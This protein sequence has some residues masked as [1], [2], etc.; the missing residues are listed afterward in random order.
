MVP[1][2][3]KSSYILSTDAFHLTRWNGAVRLTTAPPLTYGSQQYLSEGARA[4]LVNFSN[5]SQFSSLPLI[6]HFNS[7]LGL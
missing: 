7:F 4:G 1:K 3:K 5:F 2:S 6:F